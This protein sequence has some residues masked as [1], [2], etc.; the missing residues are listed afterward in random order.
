MKKLLFTFLFT[1]VLSGGVSAEDERYSLFGIVLGEDVNKYNPQE[2]YNENEL[3][4][5]PPTP[6]ENFILYYASVNKKT[7][8]IIIIGGVHRKNYPLGDQTLERDE[9]IKNMLATS[10]KCKVQNKNLVELITEGPQFKKFNNT[11]DQF[12][13][14]VDQNQVYIYD[15]DKQIYGENGNTKFSVSINCINKDG[16]LVEGEK[17]G[18]RAK[19]SLVD[20]RNIYQAMKDN[21]EFNKEKL[22]KSGLQ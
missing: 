19:I 17:I 9:L 18:A 22:D 16:T 6:N 3:I 14:N 2:G 1:L 12:K 11:L 10:D 21:K 15:G 13:S 7:N 20:F 5:T 8:K 4:V